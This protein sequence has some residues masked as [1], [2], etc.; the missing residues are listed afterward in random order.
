MTKDFRKAGRIFNK[1]LKL[2][3]GSYMRLFLGYKIINRQIMGLRPPFIVI[4]NHTNFYDP[5]LLSMCIPDPVH[6]V[7]SDAYF[8]SRILRFLLKLVGA[9]PKVKFISDPRS[10]KNILS[11]VKSKGVIGIF[12]EGRRN[13]DGLTLPLV[14]PTAKLAKSLKIPVVSVLFK[15]ACLTM[16]RWARGTRRGEL[17]MTCSLVLSRDDVSERSVDEIYD[18]MTESLAHDEYEWQRSRMIPYKGRRKAE[19]LELFIFRCPEC[20]SDNH[21]KSRDDRF[22][23]EKCNYTVTYDEYGFFKPVSDKLYFD[24][25][26]D[27]NLWQ[28]DSLEKAL[29][30]D[31]SPGPEAPRL[32]DTGVT[33]YVGG[34]EGSLAK[35]TSAGVLQLYR[36]R[37]VFRYGENVRS[38]AVKDISGEN[39]QFNYAFEFRC[40]NSVYRFTGGSG[41]ISAYKWAKALEILKAK[42]MPV[43]E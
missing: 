9:I 42:D 25:P 15:G 33:G 20:G 7:A 17:T 18:A 28:L 8:R 14:R 4:A 11:V 16:P 34:R 19:R 40:K 2:T 13:W 37:L 39:I 31:G 29:Y 41:V 32:E 26:R 30:K 36:D 12:A 35:Q 43:H 22:F 38:F 10:I 24:N 23:C 5:F 6:F 1:F 3:L 27:W 21:M